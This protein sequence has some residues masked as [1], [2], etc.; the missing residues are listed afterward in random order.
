[1]EYE[2]KK[3]MMNEREDRDSSEEKENNENVVYLMLT[4]NQNAINNVLLSI[5]DDVDEICLN[6]EPVINV[7]GYFNKQITSSVTKQFRTAFGHTDKG[8]R[9]F[10]T[11]LIQKEYKISVV[12]RA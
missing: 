9:I 4:R 10:V 5:K 2:K 7:S 12:A 3:E 11:N 1:M 6:N 8:L